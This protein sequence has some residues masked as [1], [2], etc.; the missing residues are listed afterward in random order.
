MLKWFRQQNWLSF[1]KLKERVFLTEIHLVFNHLLYILIVKKPQFD[2]TFSYQLSSKAF[3]SSSGSNCDS[4]LKSHMRQNA[5]SYKTLRDYVLYY[6]SAG[7]RF[8]FYKE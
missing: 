5:D 4:N 8:I 7:V 6:I 1:L 3:Y 2:S